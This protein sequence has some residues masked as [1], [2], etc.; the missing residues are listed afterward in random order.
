MKY[1]WLMDKKQ[2]KTRLKYVAQQRRHH[3]KNYKV[4]K[5]SL[6]KTKI[7]ENCGSYIYISQ[8]TSQRQTYTGDEEE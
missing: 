4:M 1:E 5:N 7:K 2:N 6:C 3:F 8:K